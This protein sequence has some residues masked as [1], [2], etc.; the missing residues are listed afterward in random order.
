ME[1]HRALTL[2]K[3]HLLLGHAPRV[4]L[5][6]PRLPRLRPHWLCALD[7]DDEGD[8]RDEFETLYRDFGGGD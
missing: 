7:D 5:A 4:D 1:T 8:V 2:E 6:P 3:A